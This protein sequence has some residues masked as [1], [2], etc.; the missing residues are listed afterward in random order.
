MAQ[1]AHGLVNVGKRGVNGRNPQANVVGFAK[2][3]DDAHFV[4]ER[5]ADAPAVVVPQRDVRTA[6]GR[7]FWRIEPETKWSQPFAPQLP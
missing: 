4:D 3:G 2:V 6:L 5:L 7:I 1:S